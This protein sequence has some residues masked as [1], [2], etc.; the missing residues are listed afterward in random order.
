MR[1]ITA[2]TSPSEIIG[3]QAKPLA[4]LVCGFR[5]GPDG[6]SEELDVNKPV[7][8]QNGWLWLHF[9]LADTRACQFLRSTCD[10]PLLAREL[11]VATDEH[12]QLHQS[13]TCVYGVLADLVCGLDGITEEIGFLHFVMTETLFVS[14]RRHA[15]NSVEATRRALRGGLKVVR[16]AA[17]LQ[18]IVEH[19]VEAID[20]YA[21]GLAGHLDHIEERVIANDVNV[22]RQAIGRIRRMTVRLHRQLVI[23]RSLMRRFERDIGDSNPTLRLSPERLSQ[24]LDWLDTEIVA[25]RDRAHLLQEEVTLK[26]AEQ[27]NRNLQVLA[28]VTTVFLPASLVAGIFGMNVKGLPFTENDSGFLWSIAILAGASAF[29]FWLLRRSGILNR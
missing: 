25:L 14:G 29:V 27:T 26:T 2:T 7:S 16:T 6:S 12:Q 17:L 20:R 11:L 5:F 21:E 10:L 3:L 15:L 28:I 9:N 18:I 23:M 1:P 13:D 8:D 4:G 24:R 19:V 22:H